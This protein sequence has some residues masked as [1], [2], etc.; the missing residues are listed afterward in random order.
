VASAT[1]DRKGAKYLLEGLLYVALARHF[2]LWPGLRS[3][4]H[5]WS[6]LAFAERVTRALLAKLVGVP[7]VPPAVIGGARA[8]AS[9][10]QPETYSGVSLTSGY[11]PI[12]LFDPGKNRHATFYYK[13]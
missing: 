5:A 7:T 3:S 2:V 10:K 8:P 9:G 11:F 4:R 1:S 6:P 12:G 13:F